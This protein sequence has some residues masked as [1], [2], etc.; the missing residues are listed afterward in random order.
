VSEPELTFETI[1]NY[2]GHQSSAVA[3]DLRNSTKVVR[4]LS[5]QADRKKLR[6]HTDFMIELN[7]I[8]F[9]REAYDRRKS[10]AVNDTGDGFVFVSWAERHAVECLKLAV[11]L[12]DHMDT[13]LVN[14]NRDL[15]LSEELSLDYGIGLH[16]AGSLIYRCEKIRR[17]FIYGIV[18]NTAA[19]LE[20]F[21]KNF[22]DTKILLT[23]YFRQALGT[24]LPRGQ[25][26]KW[27]C[28]IKLVT[29]YRV[30]I[31]DENSKGHTLFTVENAASLM[32]EVKAIV[33]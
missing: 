13:M 26:E 31:R 3:F 1:N 18:I 7:K 27:K 17:D 5:L 21:T 19:R 6:K 29:K 28:F 32:N 30:D 8:V 20:S 23:G 4:A 15:G 33:L 22:V 9:Q 12:S 25:L 2:G 10:Y 11:A 14:H 16:S 24:Q